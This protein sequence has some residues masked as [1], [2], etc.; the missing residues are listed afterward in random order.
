M[1]LSPLSPLLAASVARAAGD[2]EWLAAARAASRDRFAHAEP[3]SR[4]E[5]LWRYTD[6]GKLLPGAAPADGA[7]GFGDLPPDFADGTF[8]RASAY[9]LARDGVL[10]RSAVDPLLS[11]LGF[12]VEDVRSAA[13]N[14]RALVEP[15]LFALR[16]TCD[17]AGGRYDDLAGA[18]FQGGT[19]VHVPRGVTLDRPVRI[20]HRLGAGLVA[21]RSLVV[22][23][24]QSTST[25][26]F[27][28]S[29]AS[30]EDASCLHETVEIHV[31]RGAELRIVFVQTLNDRSTHAPV[32]RARIEREGTLDTV[33]VALG[34]GVVKS[35]QTAE[36]AEHGARANVL[37]IVFGDGRRHL[38][39][40]TFIDHVAPST[41]S[42]LDYRAG[43][44]GRARSSFTGR[45]RIPSGGDRSQARQSI[46]N[47]L[48]ADTAHADA[49]PELEIL[50]NE[51][52]C[53]HAAATSPIDDEQLF[54]AMS[55]GLSPAEARRLIVLGFFEPALEKVPPG[56]LADGVRAVLD[57]KLG[58]GS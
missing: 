6:P 19:F 7:A 45:L 57:R 10:L 20:A 46:R 56:M 25:V 35:L 42:D 9:A 16:G 23:E 21:S 52:S 12:L 43:V 49:I 1:S 48:L 17:G 28:L 2:P 38:D 24:A 47:L 54:F 58:A 34:G 22:A 11:H 29:S 13:V 40:H 39:H 18:L 44:A 26:V 36:L 41:T 55:R 14:R 30:P 31:G 15:K 53:S 3:P 51:V 37:G 8:E 4:A 27:D 50:T 5:H 33:N 32:I